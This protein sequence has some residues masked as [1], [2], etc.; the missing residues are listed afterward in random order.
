MTVLPAAS[1]PQQAGRPSPD[2]HRSETLPT[3]QTVLDRAILRPRFEG[4]ITMCGNNATTNKRPASRLS[5]IS[6][7]GLS[8]AVLGLSGVPAHAQ[9]E[10]YLDEITVTAQRREERLE[11]VPISISTMSGERLTSIF[12]GGEDVRALAGRIPGLNAESSNGRVAPRFYLRGLGNT[13]FDLAASQPVSIVMDEVVME[14]V[15]LKSYPLFDIERVEVLRGPQ[16]TLFG[17]NTPAGIIKFDTVKP[18]EEFEGYGQLTIGEA[19]TLNVEGAIGGSLSANDT[20]MGRLSVFSLNRDDWI[21][22]SFTGQSDALG[23]NQDLAVRGQLLF[24]PSDEFSALI[25]VHWRDY[26][27]TSEIFRANILTTGSNDLNSNFD[28]DVV[29]FNEGDN[30]PQ[31]ANQTGAS[32]RLDW[33]FADSLTLTSITSYETADDRSLGDIDGGNP[34]GPGFIP[35][36]SVTQDG[37]NDLSQLTQ[38]LR[39]SSNASDRLFWQAG[40]FYFDEEYDVATSPFFV[41]TTIRNHTNTS[42]AVFGQ[43]SYDIADQWNLTAGL[44]YTDDEKDLTGVATNF[45]VD[46]VNVQDDQVSWD[47]SLIYDASDNV[48]YYGRVANGFRGPS[49]QGRDIAFF[50]APS[51]A[52]SETITSAEFGFKSTLSDNRVR[53]NGAIFTYSVS[54]QQI[55]AVGGVAN[56]IQLVNADKAKAFGFDL[57]IDA[58]LTAD[59][60]VQLGV[61]Y[62]NTEIDDPNLRIATCGSGACTVLDSVDVDGFA[63]VDG[64]PLPNAPEWNVNLRLQYTIPVS[65]GEIFLSTDW[66]YQ[67]DMQFLIYDAAE[68]N[69]GGTFEGGIRAGFAHEGGRWEAAIFGRNITDEENL[70][71]VID[72]NNNTGFVNDRRI[73]GATFRYNFEAL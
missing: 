37:I 44:R 22:N 26:E 25:N 23:E 68:F 14:N 35:F 61:G 15:I 72:F 34:A 20:V 58:L 12:E 49:I 55:T 60:L 67:S 63:L 19:G 62:N 21:D 36:Q 32:V 41:P 65:S 28:R 11:D 42:W 18:S 53:L 47:V 66:M 2:Y 73:F 5:P 16:G 40:I 50:G 39:L 70:K 24:E 51:T 59:F 8:L 30:N 71:G 54:D 69:S 17:R 56:A 3:A 43:F 1:Q 31:E 45:P 57:D 7:F 46:P 6:G 29:A 52:T 13:D 38:E 4:D 9:T 27:G 48:N 10:I 33:D 64:N